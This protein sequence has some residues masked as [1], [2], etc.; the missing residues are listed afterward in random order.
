MYCSAGGEGD[1][2]KN[3]Q[4][5]SQRATRELLCAYTNNQELSVF[6]FPA[7]RAE[8]TSITFPAL[9]AGYMYVH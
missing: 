5:R 7:F 2:R 8:Y 6:I 4:H 9:D 3:C 1:N